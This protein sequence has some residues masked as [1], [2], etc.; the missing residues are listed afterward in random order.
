MAFIGSFNG[1]GN[2][3]VKGLN[4]YDLLSKLTLLTALITLVSVPFIYFAG[5]YAV[6]FSNIIIFLVL[7]IVYYIKLPYGYK[8]YWNWNLFKKLVFIALPLYFSQ[9]ATIIFSSIDKLIIAAFSSF[10]NV[11]YY[12][13]SSLV[14]TPIIL[15]MSSLNLVIFTRLNEKYGKDKSKEVI[16]KQFDRPY[17]IIKYIIPA[18]ILI[19]VIL[20]PIVVKVFL[21]KFSEGIIPAQILIFGIYFNTTA[22]FASNALFL[23]DLQKHSAITF[24]ITGIMNL[25]LSIFFLK[26]GFGIKGVAFSTSFTFFL[27]DLLLN[28]ILYKKLGYSSNEVIKK[29]FS[30]YFTTLVIIIIAFIVCCFY[31]NTDDNDY[32][33]LSKTLIS[34]LIMMVILIPMFY[35][36]YTVLKSFF[37]NK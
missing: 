32:N 28:I 22:G 30:N 9:A 17:Q 2:I 34:L 14:T 35:K 13:V 4:R 20:L 19:L 12:S 33:I 18:L 27:Y 36:F 29:I 11:G 7:S 26:I 25:A 31:L 21:P 15:S 16:E 37:K 8:I 3:I 5:I 24:I 23:M 6:L 10:E 1:Y